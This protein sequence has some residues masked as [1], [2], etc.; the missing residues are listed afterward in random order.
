MRQ[1]IR[2]SFARR[3]GHGRRRAAHARPADRRR[4][5]RRPGAGRRRV[6]VALR[7]RRRR[8]S[9][10]RATSTD[11]NY[12]RGVQVADADGRLTFT[13]IFPGAYSGRWPHIHFEVYSDEAEATSAGEPTVTSQI[14][15]P[16]DTCEQV[17]ATDGY[18]ASVTNLSRTSLDSD[19]CSATTGPSSRWRRCR[20]RSRRA[21]REPDRPDLI[22]PTSRRRRPVGE[23]SGGRRARRPAHDQLGRQ[24]EVGRR[25]AVEQQPGGRL[26]LAR[27]RLVHGGE[28]RIV[29][30]AADVSSNP[31]T[32]SSAG[33]ATPRAAAASSTPAATSSL[34][35][36]IGGRPL[37]LAE[38][39]RRPRPGR[40]AGG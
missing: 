38:R 5:H 1:D 28:R 33:T 12:L 3:L 13:S 25:R 4:R 30:E 34:M 35:H 19:R 22:L 8:Y 11:E 20:A 32:D 7:P 9:M 24:H 26:A 39:A 40:P 21:D 16:Q 27:H 29:A 36:T 2:S 37:G 17:Y 23:T 18:D 6:R 14:A 10:Y 31:T 15:L